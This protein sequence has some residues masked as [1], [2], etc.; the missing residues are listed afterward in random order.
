MLVLVEKSVRSCKYFHG[1]S[2]AMFFV[3]CPLLQNAKNA[4]LSFI[5]ASSYGQT[6]FLDWVTLLTL[7]RHPQNNARSFRSR[8]HGSGEQHTASTRVHFHW[9]SDSSQVK[10]VCPGNAN[11]RHFCSAGA[12]DAP[13]SLPFWGQIGAVAASLKDYLQQMYQSESLQSFLE[14]SLSLSLHMKSCKW[15]MSQDTVWVQCRI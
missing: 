8:F 15:H 7:K 2:L 5:Q 11:W 1:G 13:S 9:N 6:L 12:N 4:F 10:T 14:L 3:E